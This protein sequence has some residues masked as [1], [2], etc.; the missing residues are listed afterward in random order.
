VRLRAVL[1]DLD[2]TLADTERLHWQAYGHIL[3]EHGV[4]VGLDEYR[5]HWIAADGG[6]EYACR[7]YGLPI[8]PDELRRRKAKRYHELLEGPIAPCRGAREALVRLGATHRLAIATN[9]VRHELEVIAGKLGFV[10]L[11]HET[12]TREDYARSKPAPDAYLA[13]ARRFGLSP[14]ECA[15]VEDTPR[16]LHAGLAAGMRVIA[17]PSDL[18]FDRDFTG[19]TARLGSLDD[20][21][22]ALLERLAR[23]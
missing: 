8:T 14:E 12:V 7:T 6:P 5:A 10:G 9:S 16:G 19:A 18:T 20:L 1:F 15:V 3:R 22:A 4:E 21:D 13:A 11:L 17:V 23:S 2:G